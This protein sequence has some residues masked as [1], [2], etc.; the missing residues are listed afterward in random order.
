MD[1][2]SKQIDC[3]KATIS[4][5]SS[6]KDVSKAKD[7]LKPAEGSSHLPHTCMNMVGVCA[8]Q[9]QSAK[10]KACLHILQLKSCQ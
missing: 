4:D 6:A 2:Y 9:P 5:F 1:F 3:R 7:S 10:V 8:G